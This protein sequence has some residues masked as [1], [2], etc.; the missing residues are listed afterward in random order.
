MINKSQENYNQ[1]LKFNSSFP[2][3]FNLNNEKILIIYEKGICIYD[4]FL[5]YLNFIFNFTSENM[6]TSSSYSSKINFFQL[7]DEEGGNIF[8]LAREIIYVFSS[9]GIY[10]TSFN[11][12]EETNVEYYSFNF[13]K[14][15]ENN[16]IYYTF[17]YTDKSKIFHLSYYK[18]NIEQ[19]INILINNKTFESIDSKNNTQSHYSSAISCEGMINNQ[20]GKVLVCFYENRGIHGE[21]GISAFN[22]DKE[23]EIYSSIPQVF[24]N[25]NENLLYIKSSVSRDQKISLICS[26]NSGGIIVSCFFYFIDK[27]KCTEPKKYSIQ[28]GYDSLYFKTFYFPQT[29]KFLFCCGKDNGSIKYIFFHNTEVFLESEF[30]SINNCD[31]IKSMS[32][33][34]YSYNQ[35]YSLIIDNRC[36]EDGYFH[37]SKLYSIDHLNDLNYTSQFSYTSSTVSIAS[38]NYISSSSFLYDNNIDYISS[39]LSTKKCDKYFYEEENKC[40][41]TITEG[42]YLFDG[43][44]KII[45]KCHKSCK[46]CVQGPNSISNNCQ[47][48][49]NNSYYLLEGNCINDILCPE[50]DPLFNKVLNKCVKLCSV[51]ELING[52]CIINRVTDKALEILNENIRQIMYNH[53]I[54]SST[55]IIIKGDNIIYQISTMYNIKNNYNNISSID[56]GNCENKIKEEFDLDYLSVLK[57]DIIFNNATIVKYELFNPKKQEKIDLSICKEDKIEIFVPVKLNNEFI[58][59]YYKLIEKG[60]DILNKY[61]LFYNDICTQF[62]S[63]Y[64]TDL[65]LYDRKIEYY[66]NFCQ[67]GCE[68]KKIYLNE[69][70]VQCECQ[71][72]SEEY[73]EITLSDSFYKIDKYSNFKVI[74]CFELVFSR[75]GQIKNYG[76]VLLTIIILLYSII[77]IVYYK[78]RKTLIANLIK[79]LL[80]SMHSN[81]DKKINFKA[82]NPLKRYN[83]TNPS[84]IIVKRSYAK[85]LTTSV[86]K[87][88]KKSETDEA[89]IKEMKKITFAEESKSKFN[90]YNLNNIFEYE[91]RIKNE[92]KSDLEMINNFNDE[93]LNSLNY[94]NAKKYDKRK[95]FQYYLSLIKT[96]HLLLFTFFLNNDYNLRLVKLGLFLISISLYFTINAFFFEDNN[97][98]KIYEDYGIFNFIY[99]LP[100]I[101]YSSLITIV[102]NII[103]KRLALSEKNL[104]NIKK[105]KSSIV[106][107]KECL[108]LYNCLR[109]KIIIFFIVGFFFLM[110]FWYFISSFC[111]VYKNTQIIFLK[112]CSLSFCLSMIYPFAFNLLPGLFRI[113]S[114]KYEN[115]NYLYIVGNILALI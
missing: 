68:Y 112:N 49:Y 53:T 88:N 83:T 104:L 59:N 85:N 89:S 94:N 105:I 111:A 75:K 57:T 26:F 2:I 74:T 19:N 90:Y 80:K 58:S 113:P 5:D 39:S 110:F 52:I 7:S 91:Y 79:K 107:N 98:H 38:T 95:Y 69:K 102:C 45:K 103:I 20:V 66:N 31:N 78:K 9:N 115:K 36:R 23:F 92:K 70:K 27:N 61:D 22:P 18:L 81:D 82:S 54:N 12:Q 14:K 99:E 64:D 73:Q 13:H 8:C 108:Y 48:C 97:I 34:Y 1:I 24:T 25:V 4:Q 109:T 60:H 43:K 6:I 51:E 16:Y 10:Q 96:K 15:D 28:C 50:T 21:I 77:L 84:K 17:G 35:Q 37:S 71:I 114:L 72:T 47:K 93:E 76:S 56:I 87:K 44:N 11:I 65:N 3:A 62:T 67:L 55:N 46:L 29:N 33:V 41:E 101:I 40:L 63:K 106:R 30:E 100:K 86:L 32:I 42:F